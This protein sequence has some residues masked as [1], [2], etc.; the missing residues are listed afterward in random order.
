MKKADIAR[1]LGISR[2][3]VTMLVKSERQPS[4]KLRGLES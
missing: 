4:K 1:E 2:A 3:Y